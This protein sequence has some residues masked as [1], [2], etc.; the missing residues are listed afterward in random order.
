V[1]NVNIFTYGISLS[2]NFC[3]SRDT[4]PPA[5]DKTIKVWD[6]NTGKLL[7]NLEGHSEDVMSVA[8]TSDNSKIVSGYRDKTI[9]I[10]D[11]NTCKL[12]NNLEGHAEMVDALAVTTDNSKIVSASRDKTIRWCG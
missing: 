4:F 8:I 1:L 6:L 5:S 2:A 12:L 9:K 10:W 7:N 11:L 3:A